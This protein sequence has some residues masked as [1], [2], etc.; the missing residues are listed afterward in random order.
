MKSSAFFSASFLDRMEKVRKDNSAFSGFRKSDETRYI[1][2]DSGRHLVP[3]KNPEE[4]VYMNYSRLNKFPEMIDNSILLGRYDGH[5][6]FAT[7]AETSFIENIDESADNIK[8]RD[9][10]WILPK[11]GRI[12]G[13]LLTMAKSMV[14]WSNRTKFCGKCGSATE[15]LNGGS[16]KKCKNP[17]C[18]EEFFPRIEPS[19]IVLVEH[20]G[21][22]F[23]ARQ[24]AWREGFFS[25]LA[26]FVETSESLEEA[27][28]REVKEE[29]NIDV[30]EQPV[31]FGSDPWPFPA[32]LMLGFFAKAKS[33]D[34]KLDENEL[35]T[36]RWFKPEEYLTLIKSGEVKPSLPVSISF[37]LISRW[38]KK[39]TGQNLGEI[40]ENL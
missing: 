4:P 8:F 17:D 37:R 26:G 25:T 15:Y 34:F 38:I 39:E 1:I 12:S 22:A 30:D 11:F 23:L 31:Y 28:T 20:E 14:H 19:I 7:S 24:V 29:S 16:S 13:S 40:I 27:V 35:E 10:R 33:K 3:E 2:I 36:G 6:Y 32:S 5:Y 21:D 9:I 18:G